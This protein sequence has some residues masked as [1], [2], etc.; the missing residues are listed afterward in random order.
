MW[1]LLRA[2][3]P[4]RDPGLS[5]PWQKQTWPFLPEQASGG[6]QGFPGGG[7][8]ERMLPV[9][10][11]GGAPQSEGQLRKAPGGEVLVSLAPRG[12]PLAPGSRAAALTPAEAT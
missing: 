8:A 4:A 2:G 6:D 5:Q 10:L 1:A 9:S 12:G 11:V 7:P 3:V